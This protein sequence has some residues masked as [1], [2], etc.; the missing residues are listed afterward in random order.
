[1][2]VVYLKMVNYIFQKTLKIIFVKQL[3]DDDYHSPCL[4]ILKRK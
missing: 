3:F 2:G 1:M 4:F